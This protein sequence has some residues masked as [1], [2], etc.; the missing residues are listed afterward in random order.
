MVI[1][2]LLLYTAIIIIITDIVLFT[3]LQL[4]LSLNERL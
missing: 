4:L 1:I 3:I 2:T